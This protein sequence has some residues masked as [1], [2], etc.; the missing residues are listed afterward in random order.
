MRIFITLSGWLAAAVCLTVL[1]FVYAELRDVREAP[2]RVAE[3]NRPVPAQETAEPA[4]AVHF[5]ET[6]PPDPLSREKALPETEEAM[7]IR[8]SPADVL[9]TIM[10]KNSGPDRAR[11]RDWQQ[12]R[13]EFSAAMAGRRYGEFLDS[14]SLNDEKMA[15]VRKT[16]A[17]YQHRLMR[18]RFGRM[19][20]EED[21]ESIARENE[22]AKAALEKE[23]ASLL[24]PAD[25]AA[26]E[27]WNGEMP[28][29]NLERRV[30]WQLEAMGPALS[31]KTG[32]L[33]RETLVEELLPI[34]EETG[35][36]PVR[37]RSETY[38]A[39]QEEAMNRVLERMTPDM[40]EEEAAQ[41]GNFLNQQ[42]N[43]MRGGPPGRGG[44]RR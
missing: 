9:K 24:S 3:K 22:A 43:M 16:L 21:P 31:K 6:A 18:G 28:R 38:R 4:A 19:D 44:R 20:R 33:L 27:T 11:D 30:D 34:E 42:L 39:M 40:C 17:E 12:R 25:Y 8:V 26:W 32:A 35:G 2:G 10:S 5:P 13:A 29:R 1:V 23:L 7:D 37:G 41:I 15:E 14:L 36:M